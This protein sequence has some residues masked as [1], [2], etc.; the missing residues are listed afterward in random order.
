MSTFRQ[1]FTPVPSQQRRTWPG[2]LAFH[3]VVCSLVIVAGYAQRSAAEASVPV[4]TPVFPPAPAVLDD[5]ALMQLRL[6]AFRAGMAAG[7]EQG[8]SAPRLSN[9]VGGRT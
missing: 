4:A 8:C 9:P 3:V 5:H 1:N 6:E 7:I 2:W